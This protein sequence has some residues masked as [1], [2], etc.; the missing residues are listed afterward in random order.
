MGKQFYGE[1]KGNSILPLTK[2]RDHR[3]LVNRRKSRFRNELHRTPQNTSVPGR[4]TLNSARRVKKAGNSSEEALRG[5]RRRVSAEE[6][7]GAAGFE[8][9]TSRTRSERSFRNCRTL[10]EE[11]QVARRCDA[12]TTGSRR[13]SGLITKR[14]GRRPHSH[15]RSAA[16]RVLVG[17]PAATLVN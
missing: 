8:P 17:I 16:G 3:S 5:S 7:V 6:K 14:I 2:R 11:R 12:Q 10:V 13:L 1:W 9:T 4:S 15:Q